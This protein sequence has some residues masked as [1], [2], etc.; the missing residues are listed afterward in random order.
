M[1]HTFQ[2]LQDYSLQ[3]NIN[4]AQLGCSSE[5]S[6]PN[7]MMKGFAL[8]ELDPVLWGEMVDGNNKDTELGDREGDPDE[9]DLWAEL[10]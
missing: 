2:K 1:V 9:E 8:M 5:Y 7:M 6:M 4:I 3:Q 10:E